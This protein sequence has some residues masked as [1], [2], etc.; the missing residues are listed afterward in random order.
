LGIVAPDGFAAGAEHPSLGGAVVV[1]VVVVGAVVVEVVVVVVVVVVV[2]MLVVVVVVL[3]VAGVV[4]GVVVLVVVV[5]RG[6]GTVV[7]GGFRADAGPETDC[8]PPT[9][10]ATVRAP[11]LSGLPTPPTN[12]PE[13]AVRTASDA[14]TIPDA[15]PDLERGL[16]FG[17]R[18]DR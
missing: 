16:T 12:S 14:N 1:G 4:A 17:N 10:I 5:L 15:R 6:R 11:L 8:A 9:A 7:D 13:A 2:G 3:V 18:P